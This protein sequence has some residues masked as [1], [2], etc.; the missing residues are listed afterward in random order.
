MKCELDALEAL[1]H[2]GAIMGGGGGGSLQ[3]GLDL[4]HLAVE[5]GSPEILRLVDVAPEAWVVTVSAVGAPAAAHKFTKPMDYVRAVQ[6]I[7]DRLDGRLGGII[8]NEMGGL[9]SANGFIQSAVLGIPVI[10][11]PCNHR[12]HPIALMGSLG[13]HQAPNYWSIQ[14]AC[15][16]NPEEGRR[17][18]LLVEGDIH[19]CSAVVREASIQAGGRVVVARNPIRASELRERAAVGA[20][21]ATIELG[22]AVL[23][24]RRS[25][26]SV[27]EAVA[28][29]LGGEVVTRATVD[30]VELRTEGGF[31]VGEVILD[32]GHELVFWNEYITLE[33]Q[34]RRLYTFPDLIITMDERTHEPLRTA[35]LVQGHEIWI[36]AVRKERLIL[37]AG[38]KDRELYR[39]VEQ[40]VGRSILPY[41]FGGA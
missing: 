27:E 8:Q 40:A 23:E 1:V 15:G 30:R 39:R 36:I 6:R 25:S 41:A 19:R 14:A 32:D 33:I 34:G 9:A 2:G 29:H 20:L 22:R 11:A 21:G 13:L 31:D 16:G 35:D 38:M 5:M 24:A 17:V 37:G 26:S 18:E 28:R 7:S 10:D 4:V 12:A 3:E